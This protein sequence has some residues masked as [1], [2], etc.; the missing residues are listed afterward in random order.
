VVLR[1]L[2]GARV[3]KQG[4][5]SSPARQ[6]SWARL[7][8]AGSSRAVSCDERAMVDPTE[9]AGRWTRVLTGRDNLKAAMC[10]TEQQ[11]RDRETDRCVTLASVGGAG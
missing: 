2:L 11:C 4:W 5:F 9:R 6:H 1:R 3:L 8:G 10:M 7:C